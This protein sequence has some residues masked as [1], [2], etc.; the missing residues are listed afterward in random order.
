M[1]GRSHRGERALR[2]QA[3]QRSPR[4][5]RQGREGIV[6]VLET[7]HRSTAR[8]P[9]LGLRVFAN[10]VESPRSKPEVV[11]NP[12][13]RVV[14]FEVARHDRRGFGLP[15]RGQRQPNRLHQLP[16]SVPVTG[17]RERDHCLTARS[18]RCAGLKAD[19]GQ[20]DSTLYVESR[21][22]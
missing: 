2:H 1:A 13:R 6:D 4:S 21:G 15:G 9:L 7:V 17:F 8:H 22:V 5:A 19:G 10:D 3:S 14:C 11:L 12:G 20:S 16:D 18:D